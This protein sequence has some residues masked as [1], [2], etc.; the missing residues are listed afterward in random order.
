MVAITNL[1]WLLILVVRFTSFLGGLINI[2]VAFVSTVQRPLVIFRL[3]GI[4][5]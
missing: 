4:T 1:A 2:A 3:F 5:I